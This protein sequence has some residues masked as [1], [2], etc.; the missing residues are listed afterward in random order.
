MNLLQLLGGSLSDEESVDN[1]AKKSKSS[2]A[3]ILKLVGIVLPLLITYLTRNARKEGGAKSLANALQQHK[4]KDKMSAQIKDADTED[5][6][7]ILKHILGDD[8]DQVTK[9]LAK[10]AGMDQQQV[11]SALDA[12]LPGIMSEISASASQAKAKKQSGVDLSDGI[13]LNDIMGM[14]GGAKSSG[15]SGGSGLG[16][17]M[18]MLGGA[19]AS[20]GYNGSGMESLVGQ[21]LGG[22]QKKAPSKK[23]TL[24]GT[25]LISMLAGMM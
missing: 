6:E 22:T 18:G 9:N 4:N 13:D 17:L 5:G 8:E 3:Q 12:M 14:L 21:F 23:S 1:I 2:K 24:D 10:K 7:K 20:G 25:E 19:Q 11:K 15:A 16:A